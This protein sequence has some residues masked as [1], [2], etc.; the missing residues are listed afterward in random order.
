L[1]GVL[2]AIAFAPE[3]AL[4]GKFMSAP[5]ESAELAFRT[6]AYSY[7]AVA[8]A[9]LPLLE[10]GESEAALVGLDFDASVAWPI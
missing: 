5:A 3:D 7:K 1:D 6:S 9:L 10:A 2:H 8:G 4:G